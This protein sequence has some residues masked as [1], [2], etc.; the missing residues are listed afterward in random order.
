M[1]KRLNYIVLMILL[2]VAITAAGDPYVIDKV[3][4]G[5][6]RTYRVDGEPGLTYAWNL[7]DPVGN[8]VSIPVGSPFTDTDIDGNPIEGS[9]IEI[10]WTYDPGIYTMTVEKQSQF[11]CSIDTLGIIEVLPIPQVN[12]GPD[13]T[14][15]A[16]GLIEIT[17]SFA[18]D[19]TEEGLEWT[20]DGD[21]IFMDPTAEKPVYNPGANDL[22]TGRVKLKMS[23]K[24]SDDEDGCFQED[25]MEIKIVPRPF[26]IVTDPPA[27]CEP[28]TVDLSRPEIKTGSTIPPFSSFTY[29]E[30]EEATIPL[31]N[32]GKISVSG[33]YYIKLDVEGVCIDIKPVNV[34]VHPMP[35]L[36][37]NDPPEV[38]YPETVDISAASVTAGSDPG[39]DLTYWTD[40]S[41]SSALVN[42]ASISS[43][44]TYYIKAS[45][46]DNCEN[47]Q[48]IN[49]VVNSRVVPQFDLRYMLCLNSTPPVIP[50]IDA[51]GITGTWN[52]SSISTSTLGP[53]IYTFSPN[54]GQ[55]AD[56]LRFEINISDRIVPLFSPI[57]PLCIGST[58]PLLQAKSINDITGTWNPAV[59]STSATG[60]F[61]FTFT[62]DPGQ[63]AVDTTITIQIIDKIIPT[64]NINPLVCQNTSSPL[65]AKS[66]EG[67]SGTWS[68][69][70]SASMV[71]STTTYTFTPGNG[72]C[73][74]STTINI[75]I[76]PEIFPTFDPIGPLCL[77]SPAP[78]LPQYSIEGI[79][80]IWTPSFISTTTLGIQNYLFTPT[81]GGCGKP[82]SIAI[83]I[84][85]IA[86]SE[87]HV[88]IGT[89]TSPIGSINL[90]VSGG[91]GNYKYAWTGPSGFTSTSRDLTGLGI[92]FYEVTVTDNVTNC[93]DKLSVTIKNDFWANFTYNPVTCYGR[94]DGSAT[95]SP[96][97]G[98]PPYHYYWKRDGE[99]VST[100]ETATGLI[101]GIYTF[102]ATDNNGLQR[103][104]E[105]FTIT[106]PPKLIR[107]INY[108]NIS[109][110]GETDGEISVSVSGGPPGEVTVIWI[111]GLKVNSM[112]NL[113]AGDYVIHI[114]NLCP[115]NDTVVKIIEP[116]LMT[117][118]GKGTDGICFG[119]LGSILLTSTNIP[120]G[121]YDVIY[122][123]GAFP[124]V[125]VVKDTARVSAP[126]GTYQNLRIQVDRC[127]VPGNDVTLTDPP[128]LIVVAGITAQPGCITMTGSIRVTSPL[129]SNYEYSHDGGVTYQTSPIFNGLAPGSSH[130]IKV[131]D[132]AL[133]CESVPLTFNINEIPEPPEAPVSNGDI[134][135]CELIPIQT[136]DARD[137]IVTIPGVSIVWFDEDDNPVSFPTL[138][139]VGTK[140]YYAEAR[141]VGCTSV[142]KTSVK[143][144]L[145]P[146]P[147]APTFV[148][149]LAECEKSPIQTLNANNGITLPQGASVTWY[150]RLT[151]GNVVKMPTLN[152]VNSVTYYAEST[153]GQCPGSPRTP[154]TL[155][156]YPSPEI[157]ILED[158]IEQCVQNPVQTMDARDYVTTEAGVNLNWYDLPTGRIKVEPILNQVGKKTYY[159][160]AFNG[161]CDSTLRY[162]I[163]LIMNPLP[164]KPEVELVIKPTCKVPTGTAE[165]IKPTGPE[166][167]YRM[168]NGAYQ[169]SVTFN[170]LT[171]GIHFFSVINKLT[172][173][174]S[175]TTRINIPD[176][177]PLPKI[178]NV[179]VEDCICYGD[180]GAINFEFENVTDGTYVV[181]YIGGQF[182]NVQVTDNKAKVI[183]VAGTYRVLAIEVD[184]CTSSE[185]WNVVIDQPDQLSASA[186]IT[187]IDLKSQQK[188]EIDITI[189]GGT[190]NY[191][192]IW[193]PN[194]P[195]GFAGATTED[196]INLNA[197]DYVVSI[198]DQNGCPISLQ[199]TIPAANMPPVA[200]NDEFFAK[201]SAISGDLLY[202]DNGNGI[203]YDPD[204]DTITI[205]TNPVRDVR[206]GTLTINPDGTFFY[207]AFPGYTGDD[208]FRYRIFDV[209]KNYSIP[210]IVIIHVVAD[211]DC[212]GIPDDVDPDADGDGILNIDEG[213]LTADS[214]GDG[215]PNWL[216][217]DADNDGIVDNIEGQSTADYRP[218]MDTDTDHDGINDAYDTDNGGIAL[219]PIDTDGDGIQDFLD[220]DSDNDG[221]PDYIEGHDENADGKIDAGHKI[222]G[223]DFDS[224]GLDDAWD[225]ENR[226]EEPIAN[227]TGSNSPIQDFDGDGLKDWRDEND[228]DDEYLTRFEDLNMDG[229]WSNDDTDQDGHPEYLDFG[230]DC[231][232]F[233]PNAFSPNG[234]NIHDYFQ[235]YCIDHFPNAKIYIFDQLGNKL[236]EKEHYGNLNEWPTPQQAWWDG[237][238]TNRAA[239]VSRDGRVVP[240]TYFYVL[241]LGN[242]EVRKSFVFVSY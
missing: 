136:L 194:L 149:N 154:V 20:T 196:I 109:C 181:I 54:A 231:D 80:G 37:V 142:T 102:E 6:L 219:V 3:C 106:E 171:P 147:A 75:T 23:A 198:T 68:P 7:T 165:I 95:A 123:G 118:K 163:V 12:A 145:L 216:D 69:A 134:V 65:P 10:K 8:P 97:G 152:S 176:V 121:V 112:K 156:I 29:W 162:P 127:L 122:D 218:P 124:G 215:H 225:T 197:G 46:S 133:G 207:Q 35:K 105:S 151:G 232:L 73:A 119:D 213:D 47:I 161:Q 61:D 186:K 13:L 234:D 24:A 141:K 192:A 107:T 195:S 116:P 130:V 70:F 180:S 190:G 94:A 153:I 189:T 22:Q 150:D 128:Q 120:D 126:G 40:A 49:V 177:P 100:D 214:D 99:I 78:A 182:E 86:L 81:D 237:R 221:V 16:G 5:A 64:F 56:T 45:N 169:D 167:A 238:T 239:S 227:I 79:S 53:T 77:N 93:T 208:S 212:D 108:Q 193:Q 62:P 63:C 83:E 131:K 199:V 240:G 30:D 224:D 33:T 206:H 82:V 27:V 164:E 188:G 139:T 25:E 38:C 113:P 220:V 140:T 235:I 114:E 223:K 51:N 89:S 28:M 103:A 125:Q 76:V 172:L 132:T 87:T 72:E 57:G 211:F 241:Q 201:C 98:T 66:T 34:V 43:G 138:N 174:E 159:V 41:A 191:S 183:A 168:D 178:I 233:I 146:A 17:G 157:T 209:K 90:T 166:F 91:S 71:G 55:C 205:D 173:C 222:T 32:S 160:E 184:G 104:P 175:D 158:T 50:S 187:E 242:G 59:I 21:G 144:T 42:Y 185:D 155:T 210:A 170:M 204:G 48:P 31:A 85:G 44:G 202:T 226:F 14:V 26:L 60:D 135:E 4:Q 58:P 110:S 115:L 228:D 137:A 229:D 84:M 101:A 11:N 179:T 230:R 200:T 111:N 148:R 74:L 117:I 1:P 52:P 129:G 92:G 36:V 19:V 236:Y 9:E 18:S 203:D 2:F 96:V 15:C 143:L 39:L 88:D 67:I 217:I